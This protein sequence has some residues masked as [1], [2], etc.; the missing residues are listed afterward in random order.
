MEKGKG[1]E[2]FKQ[3]VEKGNKT[4]RLDRKKHFGIIVILSYQS[5]SRN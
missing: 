1:K 3:K 5:N 2:S 4:C